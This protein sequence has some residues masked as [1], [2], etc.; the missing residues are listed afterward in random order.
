[1]SAIVF[2]SLLL[3]SPARVA[4]QTQATQ[5]QAKLNA[6]VTQYALSANGLA[7]AILRIA[8]QFELPVGVEWLKDK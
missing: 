2:L 5:L 1:M 6:R 3:F 7:D 8:K 4:A